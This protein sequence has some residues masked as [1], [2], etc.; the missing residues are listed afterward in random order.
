MMESENDLTRVS[1]V[2]DNFNRS[3]IDAFLHVHGFGTAGQYWSR[4]TKLVLMIIEGIQMGIRK[5][6][7]TKNSP[8]RQQAIE[9]I[10]DI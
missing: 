4:K 7:Y 9:G 8:Q 5:E 2:L 10:Q 3:A 1:I 6:K